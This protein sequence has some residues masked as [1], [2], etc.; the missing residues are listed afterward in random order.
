MHTGKCFFEVGECT[1]AEKD[2]VVNSSK[3]PSKQ[4]LQSPK[5]FMRLLGKKVAE[6]CQGFFRH[7]VLEDSKTPANNVDMNA[8]AG[9]GA[10]KKG[11]S[12]TPVD[13][14]D[15]QKFKTDL[16]IT[17]TVSNQLIDGVLAVDTN[18][19]ITYANPSVYKI[20]RLKTP[21][22]IG[23]PLT[24]VLT[25]AN[26]DGT[27]VQS[28]H[29]L[30]F[31][32]LSEGVQ[33]GFFLCADGAVI[34]AQFTANVIHDNDL[35]VGHVFTIHDLS[36]AQQLEIERKA[37][38]ERERSA[39]SAAEL[40][41][42]AEQRAN[43]LKDDFLA[44][45]SHEL[46]T[47]LNIIMGYA[48]LLLT[49][50][51]SPE[52][53]RAALEAIYRNA[54]SQTQIVND[55][56]DVSELTMGRIH[57]NTQALSVHDMV[58]KVVESLA[59]AARTKNVSVT[60]QCPD[61]LYLWGDM[62]RLQQ[63]LWNLIANAIKFTPSAGEVQI[64]ATEPN[65]QQGG[66]EIHIADNGQGIEPEM[67]PHVFERFWQE[68]GSSTRTHGGLGLGLALVKYIAELHGGFVSA[69]SP[70]RNQ[71][72]EFVVTLPKA[73][74]N[75][76]SRKSKNGHALTGKPNAPAIAASSQRKRPASKP[77]LASEFQSRAGNAAL[78][79]E[80]R[81]SV[82]RVRTI[83]A[84]QTSHAQV[85]ENVCVLVVDDEPG[86]RKIVERI[87]NSHGARVL[88]AATAQEAYAQIE[89]DKPNVV[90]S[91]IM[92]PGEDGISFL[93][94]LRSLDKSISS[95]PAVA[96]SAFLRDD[97]DDELRNAGF[98]AQLTKPIE[99]DKLVSTIAE[100]A[101]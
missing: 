25:L 44:S 64:R 7:T 79:I 46:R 47:P 19:D 81:Q 16:S 43:R 54:I 21:S 65:T 97:Q 89:L 32:F 51:N 24:Q 80:P 36:T 34:P 29:P 84:V 27:P 76:L 68:D 1:P 39:R 75:L 4:P 11:S 90:I 38:L 8:G 87:L 18:G 67:L 61:T 77:P 10:E 15:F 72:A 71:G 30:S 96:L 3:N 26:A 6:A 23:P 92:M 74:A 91:D 9:A 33:K 17:M 2:N 88:Q 56:L 35:L 31:P 59:F 48:D 98:Q 94:R 41:V 13:H 60:F 37:L 93:R 52:E 53:Q 66:I 28:V 86:A 83:A 22:L 73:P 42:S 70:G 14:F 20:F 101:L 57:L 99:A 58:E 45:L 49:E 40:M 63:V 95:I 78:K 12:E 62:G 85:L 50:Q 55:L 5:Q 82:Q 69:I 100:L